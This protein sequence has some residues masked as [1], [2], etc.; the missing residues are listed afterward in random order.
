M[1]RRLTELQKILVAACS[2]LLG[3]ILARACGF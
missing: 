3:I 2:A 1:T